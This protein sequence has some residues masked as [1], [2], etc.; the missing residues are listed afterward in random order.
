MAKRGMLIPM[1]IFTPFERLCAVGPGCEGGPVPVAYVM[2]RGEV[3]EDCEGVSVADARAAEDMG[4]DV[5][6]TESEV[7]IKV[8]VPD[9]EEELCIN[10]DI[11]V[12]VAVADEE[13][14]FELPLFPS[15][16]NS[17]LITLSP[18]LVPLTIIK[19]KIFP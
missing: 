10:D 13:E 3:G 7:C 14:E 4:V 8:V 15:T 19:E 2:G 11:V 5:V 6:V 9:V 1:P 16:T 17:A 18:N 12:S